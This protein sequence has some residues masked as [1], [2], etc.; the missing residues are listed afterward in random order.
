M[1]AAV[2][3]EGAAN[4]YPACRFQKY[5]TAIRDLSLL[6]AGQSARSSH[7]P[8]EGDMSNFDNLTR[9]SRILSVS[10]SVKRIRWNLIVPLRLALFSLPV[11]HGDQ[12]QIPQ[13]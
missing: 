4:A 7:L 13:E 5:W 10:A 2:I 3:E 6:D 11:P 1:S 12:H 8:F 9:H